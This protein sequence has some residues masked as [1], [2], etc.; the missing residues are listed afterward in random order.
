MCPGSET[1]LYF[2][3]MPGGDAE[4]SISYATGDNYASL[5]NAFSYRKQVDPECSCKFSQNN[6][7]QLEEIAGSEKKPDEE[8]EDIAAPVIPTPTFR[9][10]PDMDPDS[11]MLSDGGLT[12]KKLENL[13]TNRPA[14][15]STT[16][17]IRIVGPA[18]FP[19]Q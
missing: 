2:H 12:L 10:D 7:S 18:F 1:S 9:Q 13:V 17:Q 6:I 16:S 8:Q 5:K 11:I 15:V 3:P 4:T 14:E 19:V